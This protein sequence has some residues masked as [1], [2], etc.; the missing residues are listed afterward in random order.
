MPGLVVK[1]RAIL[2]PGSLPYN[3]PPFEDPQGFGTL[4]FKGKQLDGHS[5]LGERW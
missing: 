2:F 5:S 4:I 1:S 3:T